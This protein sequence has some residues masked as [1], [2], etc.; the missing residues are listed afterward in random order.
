MLQFTLK[1]LL[2]MFGYTDYKTF[3]K[4]YLI[5]NIFTKQAKQLVKIT[6]FDKKKE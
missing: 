1:Y 6:K 5:G 3:K 2:V 4:L